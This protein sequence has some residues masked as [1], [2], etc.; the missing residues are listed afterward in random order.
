MTA[1]LVAVGGAVGALLR[2]AVGRWLATSGLPWATLVVNVVGS[3]LLGVVAAA[4]DGWPR[5]L[6]GTGVAGALTTY[7]AFALETVLLERN[8]RRVWAVANVVGSLALG[9][10]GFA[11]G[12]WL[13]S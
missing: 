13:G 5:T 6:L 4:S 3:L 1:L 9:T 10:A 8:G 11:F 7:S 2:W 12:W